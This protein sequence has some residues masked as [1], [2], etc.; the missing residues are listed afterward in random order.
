MRHKNINHVVHAWL[1]ELV[2]AD[3]II[4]DATC[5]QGFD[6][7]FCLEKG[8]YVHAF[9]IQLEAIHKTQTRCLAYDRLI[10][11]HTSHACIQDHVQLCH[12][13]IFNLGYLPTSDKQLITTPDSTLAAF[14]QAWQCLVAQ[15][16]L[17]VTFYQGHDGGEVETQRGMAWLKAHGMIVNE[18]TYNGVARAPIAVLVIKK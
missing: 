16:W 15:G 4:I 8:A 17:C 9:D 1:N 10:L 13:V 12:G 18:Y 5:G 6:T 7:A 3:D 14:N 11:H 2:K